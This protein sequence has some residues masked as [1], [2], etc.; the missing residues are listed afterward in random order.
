MIKEV[1]C[2]PALVTHPGAHAPDDIAAAGGQQVAA[3]AQ[4]TKI[5]SLFAAYVGQPFCSFYAGFAGEQCEVLIA[6]LDGNAI[7]W[8]NDQASVDETVSFLQLCPEILAV[9][10]LSQKLSQALGGK[11]QTGN[12]YTRPLPQDE[13]LP[14]GG[15]DMGLDA[16]YTVLSRVFSESYP[17]EAHDQWYCDMSHRVRRGLTAV[18]TY[19]AI[20]T[21]TILAHD[22]DYAVIN[23]IATAPEARGQGVGS[24]LLRR[25]LAEA[26]DLGAAEAAIYCG[27]PKAEKFYTSLGFTCAGRW[28]EWEK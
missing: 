19:Q 2:L 11:L 26:A 25:V 16:A 12:F 20:S 4:L 9:N 15:L 23:Q 6:R 3:S 17:S 27:N 5:R 8:L 14:K 13:Q 21:A 24:E 10:T 7:V 22:R 28:Y 1:Q 18:Y